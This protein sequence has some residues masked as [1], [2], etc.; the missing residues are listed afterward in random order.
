MKYA[1]RSRRGEAVRKGQVTGKDIIDV[2]DRR[3]A[4]LEFPATLASNINLLY[5]Q[6]YE[7]DFERVEINLCHGKRK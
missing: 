3:K 1:K 7:E 4:L 2:G 6:A 5:D